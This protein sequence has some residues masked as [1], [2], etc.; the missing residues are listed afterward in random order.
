MNSNRFPWI[1]FLSPSPPFFLLQ[2]AE[3]NRLLRRVAPGAV[4]DDDV[5]RRILPL[6][7]EDER[8]HVRTQLP[9]A[10]LVGTVAIL[11]GTLPTGFGFP[12]WAS[13]LL[14]IATLTL[15]LRVLGKKT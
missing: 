7:L 11:L 10:L 2:H 5:E 13:M 8:H 1:N 4:V 12:W 14:G 15:L 9:Y 3:R 6:N